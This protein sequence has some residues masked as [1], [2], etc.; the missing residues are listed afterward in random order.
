MITYRKSHINVV[1]TSKIV[2][3]IPLKIPPIIGLLNENPTT[4]PVTNEPPT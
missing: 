4:P 1:D 3:P 2:S